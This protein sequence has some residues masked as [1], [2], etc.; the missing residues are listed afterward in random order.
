[1]PVQA[2]ANRPPPARQEGAAGAGP[3]KQRDAAAIA[4]A[5]NAELRARAVRL[6]ARPT[7]AL[8][9][10]ST[11]FEALDAA[12]GLGG[13]P[14]GRITEIVGRPTSGRETV[15]TRTVAA[16]I[17]RGGGRPGGHAAWVDVSG[18]VDVDYLACSGVDLERLFILSPPRPLDA[19]ALAAQ[20]VASGVFG[21]VVLDA[22]AD[23]PPDGVTARAVEQFVRTV[24]PALG[25]SATACVILSGP[26]SH[27]KA[28]AHAAAV[29]LALVK[30]GLIRRGGVFRGWRTQAKVLK[31]PGLR[32]EEPGIEVWL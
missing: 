15:A 24:T 28:V 20:A 7:A 31:S 22:L 29:R 18:N 21:V 11:G 6:G 10:V 2:R 1:M 16:A 27:H 25:R 26:E 14:R 13:L 30:V 4:E 3:E 17:G 8:A 19:L 12:T 23:L 5:V 9:A 32:Y